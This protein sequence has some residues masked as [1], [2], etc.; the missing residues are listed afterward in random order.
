MQ[1][2]VTTPTSTFEHPVPDGGASLIVG[3]AAGCDVRIKDDPGVSDR[4]LRLEY[5]HGRWSFSDQFSASGTQ[6]NGAAA[7]SGD[8]KPGD[9]LTIGGTRIELTGAAPPV[10]ASFQPP[11]D[12]TPEQFALAI[13]LALALDTASQKEGALD[14][15][16]TDK[17]E[18]HVRDLAFAAA[19]RVSPERVRHVW[20]PLLHSD[21]AWYFDVENDIAGELEDQ[22]EDLSEAERAVFDLVREEFRREAGHDIMSDA[23]AVTRLADEASDV[24]DKLKAGQTEDLVVRWIWPAP[25]GPLHFGVRVG[26]SNG[27]P[28]LDGRVDLTV[29][30]PQDP[31]LAA[32]REKLRRDVGHEPTSKE[33]EEMLLH[34]VAMMREKFAAPQLE[35]KLIAALRGESTDDDDDGIDSEST[36]AAKV[37]E[38]TDDEIRPLLRDLLRLILTQHNLDVSKDVLSLQHLKGELNGAHTFMQ[39]TGEGEIDLHLHGGRERGP[40]RVQAKLKDGRILPLDAAKPAT[41]KKGCLLLLVLPAAALLWLLF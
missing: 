36:M 19:K 6:L 21:D 33:T 31:L 24:A 4:H 37:I 25:A 7:S 28:V 1:L 18:V 5:A 15:W 23:L 11:A 32:V 30:V 35:A 41:E 40:V 34:R 2:R 38:D 20:I 8:L 10:A 39:A 26:M 12:M 16:E 13:E 29:P 9:V 17:R 27:V 3:S 14:N 22:A